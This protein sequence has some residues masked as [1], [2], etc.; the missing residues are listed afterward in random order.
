M[1]VSPQ[2]LHVE[3]ARP[4]VMVF[5]GGGLQELIRSG[6]VLHPKWGHSV[7]KWCAHFMMI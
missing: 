6:T 3:I 4:S 7:D 5:G 2:N 1:F